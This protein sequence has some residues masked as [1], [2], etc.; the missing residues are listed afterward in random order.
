M[1]ATPPVLRLRWTPG[2]CGSSWAQ[3]G[4]L[5]ANLACPPARL[6]PKTGPLVWNLDALGA[7]FRIEADRAVEAEMKAE[8]IIRD[9]LVKA[10]AAFGE[11]D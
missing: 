3:V 11:G 1:T 2:N 4:G 5:V 8:T 7:S 6:Q 10:L 9:E